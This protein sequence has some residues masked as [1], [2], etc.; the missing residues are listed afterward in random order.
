MDPP[1]AALP[2]PAPPV[3]LAAKVP[4]SYPQLEQSFP[5]E[6]AA[7]AACAGKRVILTLTVGED[8]DVQACRILS[9]SAPA[10]AEAAR[11]AAL[12]YRFKP[13]L[14]S[15]GHPVKATTTISLE[16]PESP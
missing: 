11:R 2:R 16:F 10:C 13:A 4:A 6:A 14:D 5:P 8:G 1:K 15:E 9:D 7:N 3:K 12:R